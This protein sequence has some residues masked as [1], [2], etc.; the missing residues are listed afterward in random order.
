M[1]WPLQCPC[2]HHSTPIFRLQRSF[3]I[4]SLTMFIT[5]LPQHYC[6]TTTVR[7]FLPNAAT[8]EP[9]HHD[10]KPSFP[11][12]RSCFINS[13]AM[14]HS[15][16]TQTACLKWQH[17]NSTPIRLIIAVYRC[18]LILWPCV[19]MYIAHSEL[20]SEQNIQ[21]TQHTTTSQQTKSKANQDETTKAHT[22]TIATLTYYVTTPSPWHTTAAHCNHCN[23]HATITPHQFS[24]RKK[25]SGLPLQ[26][27]TH[28]Q[29]TQ[30]YCTSHTPKWL[31]QNTTPYQC[32]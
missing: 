26:P 8:P 3:C 23:A 11:M 28:K 2:H 12:Q 25:A 7:C 31:H 13:P 4:T 6:I 18:R 10:S 16:N 14:A 17:Q 27:C 20:A 5:L 29:Q 15:H 9:C 22:T 21:T 1:L 24:G 30:I 32:L 19:Q